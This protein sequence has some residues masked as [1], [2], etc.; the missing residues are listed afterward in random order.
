MNSYNRPI[1]QIPIP[2]GYEAVD[3]R[4]PGAGEE[5][6]SILTLGPLYASFNSEGPARL[7]IK[8]TKLKLALSVKHLV[9]Y[10][11]KLPQE[12]VAL[13]GDVAEATGFIFLKDG[14]KKQ[15]TINLEV[16]RATEQD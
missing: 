2:E 3:F 10:E 4:T 13:L 6:V 11:L 5:Y 8:N 12:S 14:S 1:N 15:F 16:V 9:D 7:I